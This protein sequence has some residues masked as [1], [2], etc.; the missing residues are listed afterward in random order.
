[1]GFQRLRDHGHRDGFSSRRFQHPGN[2][3][4][5]FISLVVISILLDWVPVVSSPLLW[6]ETFFH[7]L[8]HGGAAVLT[9]G[10]IVDIQLAW[11]GSGL[12]RTLGGIPFFVAFAGYLG[13]QMAGAFLYVAASGGKLVSQLFAFSMSVLVVMSAVFLA[14]GGTT[15]LI[16]G[17]LLALFLLPLAK[18]SGGALKV[19]IEFLGVFVITNSITS[20]IYQLGSAQSDAANLARAT[21]IPAWIWVLIWIGTGV[22]IFVWLFRSHRVRNHHGTTHVDFR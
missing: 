15:L 11:D 8:A 3:R 6:V 22:V 18:L 19:F 9:G 20:P 21:M 16:H 5:Y 12:C 1:M 4:T 7:E 14:T 17:F 13:A 2:S 10:G